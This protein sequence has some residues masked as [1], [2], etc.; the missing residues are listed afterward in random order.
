M[1][2]DWQGT[3]IQ[4]ALDFERGGR[5]VGD[6]RLRHSN[7]EKPLGYWPIPA[8]ILAG[9][10]G[11]T[12][13]LTGGTH[14]DE[15]EGPAA[16]MRLV[17]ALDPARLRGR[18]I[19]LPALN[20]PAV[21]RSSRISPLDGGNLNRAF[22]GDRDGGPT[23]QIAH[24]VEQILLPACDAAIDLHSGGKAS[25][26]ANCSLATRTADKALFGRNLAL[27]QAFGAPFIWILG[28][29]ND[30]RSLNAAAAR[31]STPMIA[32][33]LSGAGAVDPGATQLAYDG[34]L[35]CMRHLGMLE[36]APAAQA[37]AR[38][39]EI[40]SPAHTLYAPCDGLFVRLFEPG[41]ATREGAAA[42]TLHPL[43]EPERPP[44][45]L[46][47]PATG[48]VLSRGNRGLVERGDMLATIAVE[49][50]EAA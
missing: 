37:G 30:D 17:H 41:D 40:A 20:A 36:D 7:A 32:A 18:L 35:R 28:K 47:F 11:P 31:Q 26:F 21:A 16:L 39:I 46:A 19:V 5:Q 10:P 45:E 4:T 48:V 1:A 42:G 50:D 33:E 9:S 6:L 23:G 13:L 12:L 25:V 29:Y 38:M 27:A 44:L 24:F 2:I 14:G 34:V 49:C 3:R 15:F 22:P 43:F 8:A